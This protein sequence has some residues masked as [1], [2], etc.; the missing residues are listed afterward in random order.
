M[1][2]TWWKQHKKYKKVNPEDIILFNRVLQN[3][4]GLER[5]TKVVNWSLK[6]GEQ[7]KTLIWGEKT[8]KEIHRFC[9]ENKI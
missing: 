9:V 7:I 4:F 5:A 3:G 2:S 8:S 1:D 6:T